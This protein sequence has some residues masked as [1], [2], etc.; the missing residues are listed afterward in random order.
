MCICVKQKKLKQ[1]QLLLH[2]L[3]LATVKAFDIPKMP[4]TFHML[5]SHILLGGRINCCNYLGEQLGNNY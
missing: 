3:G 4:G 2:C 1:D 5:N